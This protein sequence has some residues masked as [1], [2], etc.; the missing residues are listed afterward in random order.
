M[1]ADP[2]QLEQV[3]TNLVLNARDAM[4]KGG[5]ILLSVDRV[6]ASHHGVAAGGYATMTVKD[7]GK[8]WTSML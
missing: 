6:P 2:G 1:K 5:Q 3:I 4:P 7:D 8:A